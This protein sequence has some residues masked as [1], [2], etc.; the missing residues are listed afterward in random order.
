MIKELHERGVLQLRLLFNCCEH[1]LT[2]ITENI[3]K[4]NISYPTCTHKKKHHHQNKSIVY[5]YGCWAVFSI[6][7]RS[8]FDPLYNLYILFCFS[9]FSHALVLILRPSRD[10]VTDVHYNSLSNIDIHFSCIFSMLG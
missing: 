5:V 9:A 6:E 4:R 8:Q 7:R 3:P 10:V 2:E 1:Y